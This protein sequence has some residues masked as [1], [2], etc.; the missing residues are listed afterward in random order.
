MR[1]LPN[2]RR[3][4]ELLDDDAAESVQNTLALADDLGQPKLAWVDWGY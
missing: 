1:H 4:R 3:L 2:R